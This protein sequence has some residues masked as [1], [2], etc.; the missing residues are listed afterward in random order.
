MSASGLRGAETPRSSGRY[1]PN[2]TI[3]LTP[4]L[5]DDYAAESHFG[6]FAT[7]IVSGSRYTPEASFTDLDHS[8]TDYTANRSRNGSSKGRS[9]FNTRQ[10]QE[11]IDKIHSEDPSILKQF[12]R[13]MENT[14][15]TPR[16]PFDHGNTEIHSTATGLGR[17]SSAWE[18]LNYPQTPNIHES[19]DGSMMPRHDPD[20]DRYQ[21]R[22][23]YERSDDRN[24]DRDR[25]YERD[26]GRDDGDRRH[27]HSNFKNPNH[28]ERR[29]GYD[30]GQDRDRRNDER[31][32]G[33]GGYFRNGDNRDSRE[34]Y[35]GSGCFFE[36][37]G[38]I[39]G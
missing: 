6:G 1:T 31:R 27:G 33:G 35:H 9:K 16:T 18:N 5:N 34:R 38:K 29:N 13:N 30:R 19:N 12:A 4:S 28:F 21:D 7:T 11:M 36:G 17:M 14:S 23:R 20:E 39:W 25:D 24:R 15:A 3:S 37:F 26:R 10:M 8:V 2:S 22:K 32:R